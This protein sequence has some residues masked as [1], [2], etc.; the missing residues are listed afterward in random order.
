P[1]L[2]PEVCE[3][4][5]DHLDPGRIDRW[6]WNDDRPTLLT[7]ALVCRGWYT[8]SR[9]VLFEEPVLGTRKKAFIFLRSLKQTPLL[10]A[11]VRSLQIRLYKVGI[12]TGRESASILVMLARKLPNLD[13]LSL[14][15]VSFEQSPIRDLA[16]WSLH[17]FS[18]VT[19]LQLWIVTLPSASPFFQ[20]ICSF[21][22][23]QHLRLWTLRWSEPRSMAPLPERHRMPLTTVTSLEYD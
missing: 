16:F 9:A 1:R 6:G 18:H 11:R 19:S 2:P 22:H 14:T 3:R 7:C 13:K 5:I 4:I 20:V 23:L 12:M 10:G 21:P 17:E 8:E 15:V